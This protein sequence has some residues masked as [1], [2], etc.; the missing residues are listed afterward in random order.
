MRDCNSAPAV[1]LPLLISALL[2]GTACYRRPRPPIND[3][4]KQ[5]AEKTASDAAEKYKNARNIRDYVFSGFARADA[6]G[7]FRKDRLLFASEAEDLQAARDAFNQASA[8]YLEAMNGSDESASDLHLRFFKLS[9][10]Y[11]KW[12]EIAE[13]DRL[14]CLEAANIKDLGSFL[15]RAKDL[16][17]KARRL[18]DEVNQIITYA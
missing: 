12:A 2:L 17:E 1:G 11:R 9:K 5:E 6:L 10:A 16:D 13:L 14:I 15:D 18:N 7:S 4:A 8:K 3:R